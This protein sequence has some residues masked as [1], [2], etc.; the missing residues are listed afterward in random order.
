MYNLVP[1]RMPSHWNAE[2][3]ADSYAPKAAA[4]F[5]LPTILLVLYLILTFIT[6][7]EIYKENIKKSETPYF[8]FRLAFVVFMFG[9]YVATIIQVLRPFSMNYFIIP[10]MSFLFLFV[11]QLLRNIKR[12]FFI[13]FRTPWMLSSEKVWDA[14]N[15]AASRFFMAYSFVILIGLF[16]PLHS[17]SGNITHP[18]S[19]D[20]CAGVLFLQALQAG[21]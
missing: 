16:F 9:L 17:D 3:E 18:Y 13:G 15:K 20:C 2:G 7:I 5:V 10:A 19:R 4:L 6:R 12:N 1:D 14:T 11:S 8:K 21:K